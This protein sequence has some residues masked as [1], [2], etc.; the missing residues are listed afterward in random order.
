[1]SESATTQVRSGKVE[2]YGLWGIQVLL[3]LAFFVT[4]LVKILKSPEELATAQAW[5]PHFSGWMVRAIGALEVLGAIGLIVPS[6]TRIMPR[7]TV[8][9]A[10][11]CVIL[12]IG[13]AVTHVQI[14]EASK[15]AVP[16]ILAVLSGLV[17]W[18]R[19]R[20][21]VINPKSA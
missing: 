5:V 3:A 21:A 10:I 12:M 7:L 14:G 2:N 4:G 20:G 15:A 19:S 17:A 9:A 16:V 8:F 13:A 11:G 18:G 1:M 6:A